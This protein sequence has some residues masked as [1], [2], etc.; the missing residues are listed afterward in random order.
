MIGNYLWCSGQV[1][2]AIPGTPSDASAV[3]LTLGIELSIPGN[4]DNYTASARQAQT[5]H[6]GRCYIC[7]SYL[8]RTAR[9]LHAIES[10]PHCFVHR[11]S[12]AL[13]VAALKHCTSAISN[14]NILYS[15][16]DPTTMYYLNVI[17]S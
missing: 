3:N 14:I 17:K 13:S 11:R 2:S 6:L 7:M 5:C 1:L 16:R 15:G 9:R 8:K 4:L 10:T 12:G